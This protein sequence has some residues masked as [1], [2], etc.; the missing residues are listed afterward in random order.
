MKKPI[1]TVIVKRER[2]QKF[3]L[4]FTK[5]NENAKIIEAIESLKTNHGWQFMTQVFE[6]N[7]K[8]LA[9]QIL[10]KQDK[11]GKTLT[12]QEV[13]T[14]RDKYCYLKEIMETPEK[15][16]KELTRTDGVLP[17]LDPYNK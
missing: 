2:P 16:L 8:D 1:K 4:S 7:I 14:L 12:D 6:A 15:Y 11:L 17:D 9:E 3:D 10:L 13:D 5:A